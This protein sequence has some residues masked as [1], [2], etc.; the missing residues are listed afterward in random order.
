MSA[1]KARLNFDAHMRPAECREMKPSAQAKAMYL[2]FLAVGTAQL[3][4]E[5]CFFLIWS[6]RRVIHL[7][8]SP[9]VAKEL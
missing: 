1:P 7:E 9:K 2:P 5:L 8:K 4:L 3:A 6:C